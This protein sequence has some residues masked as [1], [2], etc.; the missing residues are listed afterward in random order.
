L[1]LGKQSGGIHSTI[2]VPLFCTSSSSKYMSIEV[3]TNFSLSKL[4]TFGIQANAKAFVE[5]N[6]LDELREALE[7][8]RQEA[9]PVLVL[10]GGSNILLT[11]D[12]NGLVMR[13]GLQGEEVVEENEAS[14]TVRIGAGESW[15]EVV[16]RAVARGWGGIENLALIPGCIGAAPIQNIGAYGIELK[17]VFVYL[18]AVSMDGGEARR[19][20]HQDCQFGYRDSVFKREMKGKYVITHVAM[21]L[22]KLGHQVDTSYGAIADELKAVGIDPQAKPASQTWPKP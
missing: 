17:D 6:T 13:M 15:H 20:F 7:I 1:V 22:K 18:D 14:V 19:F 16:M 2:K 9:V 4:N 11:G 3:A 10:G 8:V 12:F 5:V 21:R